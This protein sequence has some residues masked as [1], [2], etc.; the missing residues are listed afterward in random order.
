M[1]PIRHILSVAC[2][3]PHTHTVP[4]PGKH[5]SCQRVFL[6]P[7]QCLPR[8]P[9]DV[10]SAI[11]VPLATTHV[12]PPWQAR[13]PLAQ[14]RPFPFDHG[15]TQPTVDDSP[16]TVVAAFLGPST[17]CPHLLPVLPPQS[18]NP[19]RPRLLLVQPS[20]PPSHP[21]PP[22]FLNLILPPSPSAVF[23]L[24][25]FAVLVAATPSPALRNLNHSTSSL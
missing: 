8:C 23:I 11:S 25:A 9:A 18:R 2:N 20:S 22:L 6:Q 15:G 10:D 4:P 14:P 5:V 24:H 16:A 7:A 12:S 1:D 17:R 3:T 21:P 19:K 13:G